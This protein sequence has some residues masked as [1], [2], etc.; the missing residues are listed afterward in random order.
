MKKTKTLIY[1]SIQK[2]LVDADLVED[3]PMDMITEANLEWTRIK[4]QHR[5]YCRQRGLPY[6]EH[7]HW[8]WEGK[9]E[10][11]E[12]FS[13]IQT[14]FGI[15]CQNEIQG[16]MLV[17]QETEF[18]K[19]PPD[20]GKS[21]LYIKYVET[22]PHNIEMYANPRRYCG[23]GG[24]LVNAAIDFSRKRGYEGRIGLHALPQAE[25]VYQN[26]GMSRLDR[27]DINSE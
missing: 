8:N 22:A 17:E 26:W 21:I 27:N 3:V 11:S 1:D 10:R 12:M 19:L 23:V 9:A 4:Q 16:L 5:D 14:R 20:K 25:Q 24:L 7:S 6:P 2:I 13:M 18:A 15:V